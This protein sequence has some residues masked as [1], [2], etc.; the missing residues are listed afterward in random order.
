V[1]H[2]DIFSGEPV[3]EPP[4]PDEWWLGQYVDVDERGEGGILW[5]PIIVLH[6][7]V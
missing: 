6:D 1:A 2:L 7:L 4:W 5:Q 3:F